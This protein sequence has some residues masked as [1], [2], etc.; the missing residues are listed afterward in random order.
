MAYWGDY[1]TH[2]TYS[3]GKGTIE[4]NVVAAIDKGLKEIAVTDHGFKHLVYNLRR[5]DF[6][7]ARAETEE[8][9]KKY[10]QIKINLGLE[11]NFNSASGN[12]DIKSSDIPNLDIVICGYHKFVMPFRIKDFFT[13]FMP[14]FWLDNFKATTKKMTVINTDAYLKALDKFDID[15]ISHLNYGINVDAAEVAKACAHYGTKVELNGKRVSIS[16]SDLEKIANSGAEFICNSDAHSPDRVGDFSK[17]EAVIERLNLPREKICNWERLPVFRSQKHKAEL[18][19][20]LKQGGKE[21]S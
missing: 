18:K 10:P 13:F 21:K 12:I 16:D 17:P 11:T 1:H 7:S 8:L 20:E 15:I 9:R 5:E 3:H 2:T 19:A 4:D 6:K 14:N